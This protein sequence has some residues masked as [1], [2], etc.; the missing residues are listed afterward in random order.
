MLEEFTKKEK[1]KRDTSWL[2]LVTSEEIVIEEK[3]IGTKRQEKLDLFEKGLANELRSADSID[4]TLTKIV[5]MALAADFGAAFVKSQ[6]AKDMIKT[7]V[8]GIKEDRT[9]RK[10]ALMIAD[11]F[12]KK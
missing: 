4:R 3:G 5:R 11:K 9:L 2:S 6:G 8:R 10:S 1:A 12:A 7:I